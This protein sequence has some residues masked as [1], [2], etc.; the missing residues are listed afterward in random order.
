VI[1][2]AAVTD[3]LAAQLKNQLYLAIEVQQVLVPITSPVG[4]VLVLVGAVLFVCFG[5]LN[6][7]CRKAVGSHSGSYVYAEDDVD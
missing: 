5:L 4:S 1:E 3:D 2:S 6:Y 7:R